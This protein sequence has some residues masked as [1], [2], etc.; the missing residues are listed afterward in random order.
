MGVLWTMLKEPAS[1]K[2]YELALEMDKVFGL[3]LDEAKAEE[4]KEEFP[5]EITAI[6]NERAAARAAKD[7]GKSDELRAKLDE[8]GY[9]VK[10]TKEGYTLTRK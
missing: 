5:A 8:L 6:A 3:K 10:D 1:R 4:V 9:A 7:W 2:I